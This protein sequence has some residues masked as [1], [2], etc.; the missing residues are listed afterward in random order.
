VL[1]ELLDL[2]EEYPTQMTQEQL[3]ARLGVNP[4]SLQAMLD[5]L[6]RKGRLASDPLRETGGCSVPCRDCPVMEHCAL[7]ND[8]Q[9]T[10]YRVKP[11]T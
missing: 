4:Q 6:V 2:L 5:I 9:E 10:F 7:T 1:Q 8:M 11:T 3:C